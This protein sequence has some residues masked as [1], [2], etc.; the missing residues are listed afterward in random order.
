VIKAHGN[1]DARALKNAIRQAITYAE[2]G[3]IEELT[4]SLSQAQS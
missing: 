2:T 1:S 3:L 4:T